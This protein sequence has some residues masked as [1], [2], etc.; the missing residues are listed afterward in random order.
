[1]GELEQGLLTTCRPTE[2]T[3]GRPGTAAVEEDIRARGGRS[4]GLTSQQWTNG[5]KNMVEEKKCIKKISPDE[6]SLILPPEI[7]V[8]HPIFPPDGKKFII[9]E[10]D[11]WNVNTQGVSIQ[12]GNVGK[13]MH[14]RRRG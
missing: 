6:N 12:C 7:L 11:E 1:M 3:C 10:Q 2:L 4:G 14:P 5:P 8:V 13:M 9:G